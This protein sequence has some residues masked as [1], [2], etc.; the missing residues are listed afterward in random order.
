MRSS[1]STHRSTREDV[2][3]V[4]GYLFGVCVAEGKTD[5]WREFFS[6]GAHV[7]EFPAQER[8]RRFSEGELIHLENGNPSE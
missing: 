5:G 7:S 1:E 4:V 2:E 3:P 8:R 6:P